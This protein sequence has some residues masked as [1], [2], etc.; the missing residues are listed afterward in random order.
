MSRQSF[1]IT[2]ARILT[3][4]S[5]PFEKTSPKT[6]LILSLATIGGALIGFGIALAKEVADSA[7]RT[8]ADVESQLGVQCLGALPIVS[9]VPLPAPAAGDPNNRNLSEH[10]GLLQYAYTEPLSRFAETL[11]SLKVAADLSVSG[12]PVIGVVSS[13]PGEVK[14]TIAMNLAQL[15]STSG[16]SVLLI[17]GD[18]RNPALSG[19]IAPGR[20]SGLVDFLIGES[21]TDQSTYV[22]PTRPLTFLPANGKIKVSQTAELI[23]S[24]RMEALL[25]AARKSYNYIIIDLPPLAPVVDVRAIARM[26]TSFVYVIEWGETSVS[27]VTQAIQTVPG[28]ETKILGCVLNKTNMNALRLYNKGHG[29][30]EYYDYHRFQQYETSH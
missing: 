25:N 13:I 10:L 16:K 8:P 6:G 12:T 3:K 18:M 28:I 20:V 29:S 23:G 22:H 9:G 24:P 5:E 21:S 1:P 19:Q 11:R 30:S 26:I 17:D 14:S 2:D 15:I 4:A 27:T 7:F